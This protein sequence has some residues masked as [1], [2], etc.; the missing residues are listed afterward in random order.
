MADGNFYSKI[1]TSLT[2]LDNTRVAFAAKANG[3]FIKIFG[4]TES[5]LLDAASN[6]SDVASTATSR[7]NLG[8]GNVNNTSDAD[9]P[10]STAQAAADA[11][12]LASA[13]SY[14]DGLVVGLWDDR[15]SYDARSNAYPSTGGSGAAGAIK[16]GDI[17]TISFAGT[18]PTGLVVEAGDTVRALIDTPG[19]TQA[20]WSILQNNIGYVAENS[21]NKSITLDADKG[22]DIKYSSVKSIY[23]WATGLFGT[24]ASLALKLNIDNPTSTGVRS[25]TSGANHSLKEYILKRDTTDATLTEV[26][27]DGAA[28]SG[29]TNR[30]PV[31]S[32]Q[33]LS[34]VVNIAVK[35]SGSA[36]SKQMLRQFLITNNGGVVTIEGAVTVLGTDVGSLGLAAVTATI[37]ANDTDDCINVSVTGIAA[38]NLRFTAFIVCAGSTY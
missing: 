18:L 13:N 29:A 26:T 3:Y 15:G 34:A 27:T 36:N 28:G 1:I 9:K 35:Q 30:I 22:S 5:K 8:L 11:A 7:T 19:T 23:D 14:S 16:K 31:A 17:W 24:I 4:A 33:T 10:V 20:N 2:D 6:L 25:I 38:T 12:V 37:T 32:G 21:V